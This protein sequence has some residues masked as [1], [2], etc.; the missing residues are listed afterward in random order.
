M[1]L[2]AGL[3]DATVP[4]APFRLPDLRRADASQRGQR[5]WDAW[6]GAHPG[7]AADAE[8]PE[9]AAGRYVEKL[10]GLEQAVPALDAKHRAQ[11]LLEAAEALYRP[12]ADR[13]AA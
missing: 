13:S 2:L 4:E 10:V 12:G 8:L 11:S 6:D 1:A 9:L 7:E 3:P 5:A